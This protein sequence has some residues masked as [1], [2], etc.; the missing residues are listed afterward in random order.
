MYHYIYEY[1]ALRMNGVSSDKRMLNN[2]FWMWETYMEFT[3]KI[4]SKET[5]YYVVGWCSVAENFYIT[6]IYYP[7]VWWGGGSIKLRTKFKV[8][9]KLFRLIFE[10]GFK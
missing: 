7:I 10:N 9:V 4:G 6:W 5:G 8:Q 1:K 3:I 2:M